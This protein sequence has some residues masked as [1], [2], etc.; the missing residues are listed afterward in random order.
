MSTANDIK[1]TKR[2]APKARKHF[3][4]ITAQNPHLLPENA[5]AVTSY[6]LALAGRDAAE[7]EIT[8][9][10]RITVPVVN[11]S[12]GNVTGHA[13]KRNTA[14]FA[15]LRLYSQQVRQYE[16]SL[17]IGPA[18]DAQR[19][20]MTTRRARR[21]Q[22]AVKDANSEDAILAAITHADILAT[23]EW[24]QAGSNVAETDD[25]QAFENA[26]TWCKTDRYKVFARFIDD[27]AV[28][29]LSE[30]LR[31]AYGFVDRTPELEADEAK[32]WD[33]P[34]RQYD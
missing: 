6:A 31:R 12:T 9:R 11:R 3:D 5:D 10:P 2:L 17:R 33:D 22:A 21:E 19:S 25:D 29:H 27:P 20:A 30:K 34:S 26:Q 28:A 32:F 1:P 13:V 8:K 14:A 18:Y 23:V 7:I 15:D 24:L 16:R 4:R